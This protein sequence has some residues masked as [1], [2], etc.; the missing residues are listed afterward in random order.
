MEMK[1]LKLSGGWGTDLLQKYRTDIFF[2]TTCHIIAIQIALTAIIVAIFWVAMLYLASDASQE[3]IAGAMEMISGET[4]GTD[5][6]ARQ[7]HTTTIEQF[8]PVAIGV[9]AIVLCFGFIM[10]YVALTPTRRSLDRK[11]RFVSNIAHELR[12]PLSIIRTNTD[13][14]LLNKSIPEP[15]HANL[16]KNVTEL[17]RISE[18]INN[19]LSLSNLMGTDHIAFDDV[20]LAVVAQNAV[21]ALSE[22]SF[23]KSIK[24]LIRKDTEGKVMGN[25]AAL[26][27]VAFNLIKNAIVH[28]ESGGLITITVERAERRYNSLVVADKG[29]GIPHDELFHIFEPFYRSRLSPKD[30]GSGLGLTIVNE[31]VQMHRGKI[32]ISSMR[33]RGTTVTVSIPQSPRDASAGEN[34]AEKQASGAEEVTMDFSRTLLEP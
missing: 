29:I 19:L 27:Q 5:E 22:I 4:L 11:K 17:E 26:E 2:R 18:I 14:M 31:I 34:V 16:E 33:G 23:K 12:T 24:L 15:L 30:S 3:T 10:A 9:T 28:T 20:D 1:S 13:L 6:L 25:M 21:D 32:T 7:I 8:F